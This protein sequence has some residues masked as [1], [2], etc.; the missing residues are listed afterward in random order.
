[1]RVLA[2]GGA[3]IRSLC[4]RLGLTGGIQRPAFRKSDDLSILRDNDR[5]C[6]IITIQRRLINGLRVSHAANGYDHSTMVS[7][8]ANDLG[9]ASQIHERAC[10][11]RLRPW[12]EDASVGAGQRRAIN[13]RAYLHWLIS[14]LPLATNQTMHTLTP[15]AYAAAM[16]ESA[17]P[18]KKPG[19]KAPARESRGLKST[20]Q[21]MGA[22]QMLT[23]D[24][25][26]R[27]GKFHG[28]W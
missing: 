24:R 18:K 14:R 13:P 22:R 3:L 15:A 16:Q 17:P 8:S 10:R 2:V 11:A 5:P 1:M 7:I 4:D 21:G 28:R 25:Q 12:Y 6:V 27:G 19:L 23:V 20:Q 9:I 26:S